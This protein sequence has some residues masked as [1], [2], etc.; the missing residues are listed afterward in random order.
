[1]LLLQTSVLLVEPN[2]I[3]PWVIQFTVIHLIST[4]RRLS[5][6]LY[7]HHVLLEICVVNVWVSYLFYYGSKTPAA[8]DDDGANAGNLIQITIKAQSINEWWY[9]FSPNHGAQYE[10]F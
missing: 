6:R 9:C 5:Y 7:N 8:V 2:S 3:A 4:R 10:I 1:M